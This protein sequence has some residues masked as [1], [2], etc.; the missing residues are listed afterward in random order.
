LS[1][2]RRSRLGSNAGYSQPKG[3]AIEPK[4]IEEASWL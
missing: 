3:I 4:I 2:D 1:H